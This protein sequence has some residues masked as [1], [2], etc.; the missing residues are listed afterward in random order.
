[1]TDY[2]DSTPL[3]FG[4]P[5]KE[6]K[7]TGPSLYPGKYPGLDDEPTPDDKEPAPCSE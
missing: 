2:R 3:F 7:S 6:W 4:P 5:R 1:M